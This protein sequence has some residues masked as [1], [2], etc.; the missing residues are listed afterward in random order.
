MPSRRHLHRLKGVELATRQFGASQWVLSRGLCRFNRFDLARLPAAKRKAALALQLPQW[1]P[2]RD[3]NYAII[4]QDGIASV[5]CWDN[6]LIDAEIRKH[7]RN[8]KAQQKIPESLLRAPSQNGLRLINC[9]DGIEG[10]YWQQGQ[11]LASR[12]WPEQVN[13]NDWLAFQRECGVPGQQQQPRP[14][15][16]ES[17]LQPAPWGKI[18]NLNAG[19]D[20]VTLAELAFHGLLICALGLPTIHLG[21]QQHQ[22]KAAIA[23]RQAELAALK[24]KASAVLGAR[25]TAFESL[26]TLKAIY[27]HQRYPEPLQLMAAVSRSLPKNGTFVSEWEML[28]DQL[29]ITVNSPTSAIIGTTYVDTLEKA[30][31]FSDVK[32]ITNTDPKRMTFT[33]TVLPLSLIAASS[34]PPSTDKNANA[35][36]SRTAQ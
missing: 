16:V 25:S 27:A 9:L 20:E 22:I 28:E 21:I 33:M 15:L 8:P 11:L 35:A 26:A 36:S 1:S 2:Y 3:S 12:W 23:G 7:G 17:P 30:G 6:A 18:T 14:V 5:W 32:I 31:P 34:A 24:D 4:W 10:Q 13:A 19:S 29:K